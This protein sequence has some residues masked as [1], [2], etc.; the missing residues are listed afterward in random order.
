M[1]NQI[2]T[3][4]EAHVPAEHWATLTERFAQLQAQRPPQIIQSY[5]LQSATDAALWRMIGLWPSQQA[6]DEYRASVPV[7]GA[8]QLFLSVGAQPSLMLFEVK[9]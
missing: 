2:M 1:A 4:V 3:I 7:P 6:F 5:L 9:G 8:A